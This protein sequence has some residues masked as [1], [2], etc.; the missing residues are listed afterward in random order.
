MPYIQLQNF[1]GI[2]PRTG[3]TQLEPNQAQIAVNVRETSKELRSWK[4]EVVEY[5]PNYTN[6]QTIYKLYNT[7]TG[8][9]KWLE[10]TTDVDIAVGPVGDITE[11]RI[12]YTGDGTPKKT[13]W[14]L[15]TTSGAGTKPFPNAYYNM[16]V[17]A[18]A[19]APTLVKSGGSG[20]VHEDRAYVYTNISTFGSVQEESAPSPAGTVSSVEPN[21]TVTVSGFSSVAVSG[22]N[23]TS[24]RI[25][26][27]VTGTGSVVYAF[28]AEIPVATA[29][30][31][32]T[33]LAINLGG[34]LESL[35]YT[36]PPS[37]L[38]G[39]VAMA[40]GILVGF[41]GNQVWF[42]EP[43]LPHA[44]PSN[45]MMTVNDE[46]VGLGAFDSSVVVLTKHQP[47]VITGTSP[48]G[49][50][51]VKLPMMQP[52]VSKKS[53]TTDQYGILYASPNGLVSIAS[54]TQD[55]VTT[56][57]Y[58]REE[59]Q[60]LNPSSLV[61]KVYNNLYIGFYTTGGVTKSIVISRG[62]IPPLFIFDYSASALFVDHQNAN[63]YAVS[64]IDNLV[65]QLDADTNNNT[66]YEWMSK[67]FV[68]PN[69]VNFAAFKVIANYDYISD[70]IAY[71]NLI[72]S[73]IAENQALFA[74]AG[75][76]LESTVNGS[77]FNLFPVNGSIL[78]SIPGSPAVTRTITIFIYGDGNL[79]YTTGVT[80]QEPIR[81][82]AT[83]KAYTYEIKI[84]GNA[85]VRGFDM[86]TSI[87]EL[88]A[89]GNG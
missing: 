53:I 41:T 23:I 70:G 14:A 66:F 6:V 13:N 60:A 47:F 39:I 31:A 25:Y 73:I 44:W 21:A 4:K 87:G 56:A 88:R 62:D 74:A 55:V 17:L 5:T 8:T 45:Y 64:T 11:S 3:P 38:Q 89:L 40:N 58:T 10:W 29:S 33:V 80:T 16:G 72:A 15:A 81:I 27:S 57:L 83:V 65:Y 32:D 76:N 75:G 68:M 2:A 52:C 37:T 1:S 59:W 79:I 85:P 36:E 7:P 20:T 49:M 26:R 48:G 50:S 35:Y 82:P 61:S 77:V 18:P 43:Y 51:Q 28:V 84:S 71:N 12:Y 63:I 19:A 30:Y 46:I 78:T 86:A 54:G 9:Y 22:Y 67:K 42:C 69:P 34:T 24:R